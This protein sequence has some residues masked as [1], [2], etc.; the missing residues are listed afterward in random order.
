MRKAFRVPFRDRAKSSKIG[1][2]KSA[3]FQSERKKGVKLPSLK[4][5]SKDEN[6]TG[7]SHG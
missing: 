6:K 2:A 3:K 1:A 5:L 4:F 7:G